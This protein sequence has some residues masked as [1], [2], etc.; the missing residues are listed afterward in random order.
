MFSI[1]IA[2]R[3]S[4]FC[5]SWSK[6]CAVQACLEHV[7]RCRWLGQDRNRHWQRRSRFLD[8]EWLSLSGK[9]G[10]D[11]ENGCG[12]LGKRFTTY[13][14]HICFCQFVLAVF[15]KSCHKVSTWLKAERWGSAKPASHKGMRRS[16]TGV[17]PSNWL[18]IKDILVPKFCTADTA[19]TMCWKSANT[20][21]K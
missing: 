7:Q 17:L 21:L 9:S 14:M 10:S 3:S 13:P 4:F 2:R 12:R 15:M 5:C 16:L 20:E 8:W 6:P 11:G 19:M 18:A 1:P